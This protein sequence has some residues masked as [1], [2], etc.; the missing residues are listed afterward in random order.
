MKRFFKKFNGLVSIS[1]LRVTVS[2]VAQS[3]DSIRIL[4]R[5]AKEKK[6][7]LVDQ[8]TSRKE[9]VACFKMR[10]GFIETLSSIGSHSL[11]FG[12]SHDYKNV[13][14][15]SDLGLSGGS[16]EIRVQSESRTGKVLLN[17]R[18]YTA[19]HSEVVQFSY[20]TLNCVISCMTAGQI[21]YIMSGRCVDYYLIWKMLS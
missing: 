15:N 12:Q 10:N 16:R 3:D 4:T 5:D 8:R 1:D 2:H 7:P 20:F 11:W 9:A 21:S 18:T 17:T 6:S 19:T 13:F 14:D